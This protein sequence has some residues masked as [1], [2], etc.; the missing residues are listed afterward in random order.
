MPP[1]AYRECQDA[2]ESARGAAAGGR[3]PVP[4]CLCTAADPGGVRWTRQGLT[5]MLWGRAVRLARAA[6]GC[7]ARGLAGG[8]QAPLAA[9]LERNVGDFDVVLHLH[10]GAAV[11]RVGGVGAKVYENTRARLQ[12]SVM[13]GLNP[14]AELLARLRA[15]YGRYALFFA[16]GVGADRIAVLWLPALAAGGA[17][18]VAHAE[19]TF[20]LVLAGGKAGGGGGGGLVVPDTVGMLAGFKELGRGLIREVEILPGA[21]VAE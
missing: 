18:S 11:L 4:V 20:P 3:G 17:L 1:H 9:C 16:D 8:K 15:A 6:L 10:A 19:N 21:R 7:V 13:V 14:M 5:R 12:T 2:A